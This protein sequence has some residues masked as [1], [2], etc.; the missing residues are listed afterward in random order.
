MRAFI[1][2]KKKKCRDNNYEKAVSRPGFDAIDAPQRLV[3][4]YV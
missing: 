2:K 3:R 4:P 1:V